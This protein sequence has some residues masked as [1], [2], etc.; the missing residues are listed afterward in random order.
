MRAISLRLVELWLSSVLAAHRL[1]ASKFWGGCLYARYSPSQRYRFWVYGRLDDKVA[2]LRAELSLG[3]VDGLSLELRKK[4]MKW[5][6][7]WLQ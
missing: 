4:W 1:K 6:L 2:D 5:S 3:N 7:I